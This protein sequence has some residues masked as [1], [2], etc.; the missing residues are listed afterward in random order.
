MAYLLRRAVNAALRPLRFE[1]R[2]VDELRGSDPFWVQRQLLRGKAN[3]IFDVGAH[4]GHVS[5]LY[6]SLFPKSTLHAFEPFPESFERLKQRFAGDPRVKVNDLALSDVA[7]YVSLNSN[8]SSATNS[9]LSSNPK[10]AQF[11]GE[12]RLDTVTTIKAPA[13]TIDSYCEDNGIVTIEILKLDIQGGELRALRGASSMLRRAS[14][15]LIYAEVILAPT[16]VAQPQFEEYLAF[17]RDFGYVMLDIFNQIRKDFRLIQSD[18]I[19][20]R[21]DH[22]Y[23]TK[24]SI[25]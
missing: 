24:A 8:L 6:R 19:F 4:V 22:G 10:G 13:T 21:A 18:V 9:I 2:T 7:G 15:E 1:I 14:V 12:G 25:T 23:C 11:W 5:A 3:T 16:Y 20:V 17:L